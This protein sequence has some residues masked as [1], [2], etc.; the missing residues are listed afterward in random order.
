MA[1]AKTLANPMMHC[2]D[3]TSFEA[4]FWGAIT[5]V[6]R[7]PK[8][9]Q[10]SSE[11]RFPSCS[12]RNT[13][14]T[15]HELRYCRFLVRTIKDLYVARSAMSTILDGGDSGKTSAESRL[16]TAM[17]VNDDVFRSAVEANFDPFFSRLQSSMT[18]EQVFKSLI[19]SASNE[20]DEPKAHDSTSVAPNLGSVSP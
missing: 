5:L 15:S 17:M 7:R 16:K 8:G 4:P 3:S 18:D 10:H 6:A 11:A 9:V 2:V 1:M 13:D 20:T 19:E 14:M 12:N